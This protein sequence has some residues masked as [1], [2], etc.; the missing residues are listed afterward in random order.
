[1][2]SVWCVDIDNDGAGFRADVGLQ[3]WR[4]GARHIC[5]PRC[6]AMLNWTGMF[7]VQRISDSGLVGSC[8]LSQAGMTT[9]CASSIPS[10]GHL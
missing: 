2:P 9:N 4:P 8:S 1:M 7:A 6:K 5:D 3:D 10:P